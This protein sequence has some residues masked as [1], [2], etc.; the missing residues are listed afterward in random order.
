MATITNSLNETAEVLDTPE[1][2]TELVE[3]LQVLDGLLDL[4]EE[5]LP[6]T[7]YSIR[8]KS[9]DFT[10][11]INRRI[12]GFD[13][14]PIVT[15]HMHFKETSYSHSDIGTPSKQ[16]VKINSEDVLDSE[17]LI[18]I[19]P[20]TGEVYYSRATDNLAD[21][22]EQSDLVVT[23]KEDFALQESIIRRFFQ[24]PFLQTSYGKQ[25]HQLVTNSHLISSFKETIDL[26]D[27]APSQLG[28]TRLIVKP[29]SKGPRFPYTFRYD[30]NE[31]PMRVEVS[32]PNNKQEFIFIDGP[33]PVIICSKE[34]VNFVYDA[35]S[36]LE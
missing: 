5:D 2:V 24:T 22:I 35:I 32:N 3:V 9:V 4:D 15:Y 10:V 20:L 28:P 12:R 31:R 19:N 23:E 17:L 13:H 29:S 14:A 36:E 8:S 18:S 25:Q 6:A 26:V 1:I 34:S 33:Y 11:L 16:R 27:G 21:A 7:E 30:S